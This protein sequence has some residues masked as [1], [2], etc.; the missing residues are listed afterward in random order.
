MGYTNYWTPKKMTSVDENFFKDA[1]KIINYAISNGIVL[2][3]GAGETKIANAKEAVDYE[4]N[5]IVFNGYKDEDYE[6]F[7]LSFDGEWNFCKTARLPYDQVVKAILILA[8]RHNLLEKP[9]NFDGDKGEKEYT[10]A[11]ALYRK[12]LA[13]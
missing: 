11:L 5:E 2:A 13:D 1:E 9:F 7:S 10:N 8:E 3:D 4:Y 6:T 12:A